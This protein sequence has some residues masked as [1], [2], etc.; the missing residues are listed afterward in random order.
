[1]PDMTKRQREMWIDFVTK[2]LGEE[3]VKHIMKHPLEP[4][5][6]IQQGDILL[7]DTLDEEERFLYSI[8]PTPENDQKLLA[9]SF[10]AV[11]MLWDVW[12]QLVASKHRLFGRL[13]IRKGWMLVQPKQIDPLAELEKELKKAMG[14][15]VVGKFEF[16]KE[17]EEKILPS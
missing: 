17:E 7:G 4:Q 10:P 11:N 16:K 5:M 14:K 1:M 3:C 13:G 8:L 2:F 6:E 12:W 9:W 15:A